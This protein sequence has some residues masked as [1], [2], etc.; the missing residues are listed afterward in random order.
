[1]ADVLLEGGGIVQRFVEV[2]PGE[3]AREVVIANS[4][5]SGEA[6]LV[7]ATADTA[8]VALQEGRM[9]VAGK[10][11]EVTATGVTDRPSFRLTNPSSS[12]RLV[13]VLGLDIYSNLAQQVRYRDVSSQG[14]QGTAVTARNMNQALNPVPAPK[15]S[16]YW[17]ATGATGGTQWESESRVDPTAPLKVQFPR[18]LVIGPNK[19]LAVDCAGSGPQ[20]TT[21]N[22]YWIESEF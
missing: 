13:T 18:G 17:A 20:T 3:Y 4:Q 10:A 1:M 11:I 8:T 14:N 22:L 15:A 5:A 16:A 12:G 21:I 7:Q 19:S 6:V 2:R 9:F